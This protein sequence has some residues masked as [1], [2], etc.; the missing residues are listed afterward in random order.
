MKN[1]FQV[2]SLFNDSLTEEQKNI[3]D[4][5]G[6]LNHSIEVT[7]RQRQT[8]NSAGVANASGCELC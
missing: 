3:S 1:I 2:K 5:I 4:R 7:M 8:N 6:K